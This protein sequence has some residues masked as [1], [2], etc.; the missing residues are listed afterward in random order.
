MDGNDSNNFCFTDQG[1]FDDAWGLFVVLGANARF[2]RYI[3]SEAEWKG[4]CE[5]RRAFRVG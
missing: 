4:L 5:V 1:S 3:V 2:G